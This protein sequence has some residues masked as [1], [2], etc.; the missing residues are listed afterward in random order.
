M[1]RP[2]RSRRTCSLLPKPPRER[3]SAWRCAPLCRR[4]RSGA[5][6]AR[7]V[8]QVH[9]PVDPASD[10]R[11]P[12]QLGED[13]VPQPD[14]GPAV[15]PRR[16]R[17]P[18]PEPLRQ[19]APRRAAPAEPEQGVDDPPVVLRRSSRLWSRRKQRPKPRPLGVGQRMASHRVLHEVWARPGGSA[20]AVPTTA[21]PIFTPTWPSG[22]AG[23]RPPRPWPAR[24]RRGGH[25]RWA[26]TQRGL[27]TGPSGDAGGRSTAAPA[28]PRDR[29]LGYRP[30]RGH[31]VAGEAA[32]PSPD[33]SRGSS[34][35]PGH[36]R[37]RD[38]RAGRRD[39][40]ST[41]RLRREAGWRGRR[42]PFRPVAN[43]R[44]PPRARSPMRSLI[45]PSRVEPRRRA[46]APATSPARGAG[47]ASARA[48]ERARPAALPGNLPAG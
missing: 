11:D 3:P 48:R 45:H 8:D 16:H 37:G 18:R 7:A 40:R 23:E 28:T 10:I 9:R 4:R 20:A 31:A 47:R 15:E 13:A 19:V 5:P 6:H 46:P 12:S 30:P 35:A 29:E 22:R 43:R 26:L 21:I 24:R 39:P 44:A 38:P 32:P 27:K 33:G 41:R 14:P 36:R 34:G 2:R 42:L 17:V 25:H 1:G